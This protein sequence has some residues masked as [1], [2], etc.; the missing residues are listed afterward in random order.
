MM[1][2]KKHHLFFLLCSILVLSGFT[3]PSYALNWLM[4]HGTEKPEAAKAR[5]FG[6]V[7]LDYQYTGGDCLP[8]NTPFEGQEAMFNTIPPDLKHNSEFRLHRL[9]LGIR[10]WLF[11]KFKINYMLNT[12]AGDNGLTRVDEGNRIRLTHA[13][14][15][16]NAIPHARMRAGMF[17][18]P[19][20]EEGFQFLPPRYYI[21]FSKVTCQMVMENFFDS[22][23]SNPQDANEPDAPA[24]GFADIGLMVF[25]AFMTETW[26]HSYAIMIGNGRG[27]QFNDNN[28]HKELYLYWASEWIF[29]GEGRKRQGLKLFAWKQD[30][31]R[32]LRVGPSQ[33]KKD[34]DR[35]RYGIGLSFFKKPF[36]AG[37][38][39]IKA[40]GMIFNGTDGS[41]VPGSVN[42]SGTAISSYNVLPEDKAHGW[43]IDLG[44]LIRPGWWM[45]VRYDRLDR[46][47]DTSA[48]E[49]VFKTWTLGT[50]CWLIKDR[51]R[52]MLNYE[53]RS[54]KAPGFPSNADPN[55]VLSKMDDRISL[56]FV[57]K[58]F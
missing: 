47:T 50:H 9:R 43:Y 29:S 44:Y 15:T 18:H 35:I 58:F 30:G 14:L 12:L 5:P 48:F 2:Q 21:N 10:G 53:C 4:I 25:D 33:Y 37:F 36:R 17:R 8:A 27:V 56:N 19:G 54:G 28:H 34:F 52:L 38:E 16:F 51:I 46:A 57:F 22:D 11:K 3:T 13:S 23:G 6:F 42:N 39:Y 55:R 20:A 49:R 24:S 32:N 7:W 26:E 45:D 40:D 41:A 1:G 31:E